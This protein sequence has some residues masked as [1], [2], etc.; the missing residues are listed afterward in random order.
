MPTQPDL[1]IYPH[2]RRTTVWLLL[3]AI[4]AFFCF[5]F[6]VF[7]LLLLIFAYHFHNAGAVF[8]LLIF[9]GFGTLGIWPTRVIARL[10]SSKEPMLTISRQG[11]R[12][13]QLFGS[14]DINLLWEEIETIS[15]LTGGIE[16]QLA[17][18]TKNT[19]S[20]LSHFP[21]PMRF[22]LRMNLLF[23]RAAIVISQ[24]FLA[25]PIEEILYKLEITYA[26]ELRSCQIRVLPSV[27]E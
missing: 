3:G 20:L 5:L 17:I 21:L 26:Q 7:I 11:I 15:M 18:R 22:N 10:L 14:S 1:I 27:M 8:A 4:S 12:I 23:Y 25:Q 2:R 19:S 9:A 16:L 24:S 13:G 6:A